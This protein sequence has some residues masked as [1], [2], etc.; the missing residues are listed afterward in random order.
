MKELQTGADDARLAPSH[1][2]P[3]RIGELPDDL[4]RHRRF[5]LAI[6]LG[7]AVLRHPESAEQDI[8]KRESTG[9]IGIAALL[10]DGVMPAM[11]DR[12]GQYVFER[13]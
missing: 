1:L 6:H 7:Q 4:G 3:E 8:P 10:Q 11:E 13:P 9:E 2:I 5:I 12:R